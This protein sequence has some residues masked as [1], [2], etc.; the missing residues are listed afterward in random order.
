LSKQ[1]K[2]TALPR[3]AAGKGETNR[4]RREGRVPAILYGHKVE[5]TAVS[6][7]ERELFHALNGP[8]GRNAMIALDVEGTTTLVVA[9]DIQRHA[10][11]RD[12][13]HIDLL[14]VDR[15]VKIDVEV[16]IHLTDLDDVAR[17]GGF[18]NQVR[19]VVPLSVRPL[20]TPDFIELSVAGMAIGDVKRLGDIVSLLPPGTDIADD[21]DRVIVTINAPVGA[22]A[23]AAA[24]DA[25]AGEA[26]S[27]AAASADG[28]AAA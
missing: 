2:L 10:V 5:P 26:A 24:D 12:V 27:A 20:D 22:G 19:Y 1:V 21:P 13:L 8:A 9:R 3:A 16:P 25:G 4:L 6:L 28:D 14:A 15:D 11:R 23:D 7:N 17:D 18:L